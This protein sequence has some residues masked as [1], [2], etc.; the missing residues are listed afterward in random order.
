MS[1]SLNDRRLDSMS[2]TNRRWA[3]I[4][5]GCVATTRVTAPSAGTLG[6]LGRGASNNGGVKSGRWED[7]R[8]SVRWVTGGTFPLERQKSSFPASN[9]APT[10]SL[11]SWIPIDRKGFQHEVD[12]V[13]GELY[14]AKRDVIGADLHEPNSS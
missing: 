11:G 14:A 1:D 9:G 10:Q 8:G 7:C 6:T 3:V 2:S 13:A 12:R 4:G 5:C